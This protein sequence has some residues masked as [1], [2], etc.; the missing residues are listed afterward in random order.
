M[1]RACPSYEKVGRELT[2]GRNVL[3]PAPFVMFSDHNYC[4]DNNNKS[5]S[6]PLSALSA[7][8]SFLGP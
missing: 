5:S 2:G 1:N 8:G 4:N 7:Q 3:S 6:H